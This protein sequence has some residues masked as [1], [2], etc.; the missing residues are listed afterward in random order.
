VAETEVAKSVATRE[1]EGDFSGFLVVGGV[2]DG[3][4][5][6]VFHFFLGLRH[7]FNLG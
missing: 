7:S 5:G 6:Y 3:A 2:A 1:D 4:R